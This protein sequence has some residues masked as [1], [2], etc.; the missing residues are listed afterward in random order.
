MSSIAG[1]LLSWLLLY[2]YALLFGVFFSSAL[3]LPLPGNTLL[4]A[5]GAFASQ[6]YMSYLLVFMTVLLGN[7]AGDVA[8]YALAALYGEH[9]IEKLRIKRR[10]FDTLERYVA[11]HPR[12]TIFMSRFG[13]TLD[14]VVNVLSGLGEVSFRT[15]II[16]DIIGNAVSLFIVVTAGYYLGDYWQSFSG[17]ASTIGWILF[18]IL[19]AVGLA[20]AFRKQIGL[21]ESRFFR[22]ITRGMRKFM[23]KHAE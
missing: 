4:L 2:K 8:G 23:K 11:A 12:M 15:F 21:S 10:Y 20:I 18:A 7:V 17:V 13:G 1:V 22:W 14:P 9:V 16:F 19:A 3:A 6:G 5:A